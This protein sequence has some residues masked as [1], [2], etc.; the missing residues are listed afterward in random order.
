MVQI[1][2]PVSAPDTFSFRSGR[3]YF[4]GMRENTLTDLFGKIQSLTF[5]FKRFNDPYTLLV[6]AE[7]IR[8]QFVEG[9]FA[10][11]TVWRMAQIMSQGDCFRKVFIQAERTGQRPCDLSHLQRVRQARSVMVTL[12]RQKNLCF[13]FQPAKGFAVDDPVTVALK[14]SA[15]IAGDN[16]KIPSG[17]IGGTG[18]PGCKQLRF[19][20]LQP[21]T[22]GQPE[23]PFLLLKSR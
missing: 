21:L 9:S 12:R 7:T 10:D 6:M 16:R 18:G 11:M 13:E 4:T 3:L 8:E 22:N 5:V 1:S 2:D 14:I 17:A 19:L 23:A 20:L 15:N